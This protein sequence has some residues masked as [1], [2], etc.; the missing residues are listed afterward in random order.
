MMGDASGRSRAASADLHPSEPGAMKQSKSWYEGLKLSALG[1]SA[2]PARRAGRGAGRAPG[3]PPRATFA[4][5]GRRGGTRPLSRGYIDEGSEEAEEPEEEEEDDEE[6]DGR[7]ERFEG[8]SA[9]AGHV[10]SVRRGGDGR[11]ARSAS[12]ASGLSLA[13]PEAPGAAPEGGEAFA[14]VRVGGRA[15]AVTGGAAGSV[16]LWSGLASRGAERCAAAALADA[17]ALP[18][19]P[20]APARAPPRPAHAPRRR[21]TAAASVALEAGGAGWPRSVPGAAGSMTLLVILGLEDGP[22]L[23]VPQAPA[24]PASG[25]PGC[26]WRELR[27]H[28]ARVTCLLAVLSGSLICR[29]AR[30]CSPITLLLPPP[31]LP[32]SPPPRPRLGLQRRRRGRGGAHAGNPFLRAPR[33]SPPA[34][35]A[36]SA[37]AGAGSSLLGSRPEAIWGDCLAAADEGGTLLVVALRPTCVPRF[38][39]PRLLDPVEADVLGIEDPDGDFCAGG[40]DA[41]AARTAAA[42]SVAFAQMRMTSFRSDVSGEY[43][44]PGPLP[45]TPSASGGAVVPELFPMGHA[46]KQEAFDAGG[47]VRH[48]GGH[49]SPVV[50]LRWWLSNDRLLA[51]CRD[52]S[53][54][55]WQLATG[56]LERRLPPHLAALAGL[57]QVKDTSYGAEA[58]QGRSGPGFELTEA[59]VGQRGRDPLVPVLTLHL[60]RYL[61]ALRPAPAAAPEGA[62]GG[63]SERTLAGAALFGALHCWGVD[64]PL[65]AELRSLLAPTHA[66]LPRSASTSRTAASTTPPTPAPGPLPIALPPPSVGLRGAGGRLSLQSAAC[67]ALARAL[68]GAP[69]PAPGAPDAASVWSRLLTHYGNLR[70]HALAPKGAP[71]PSLP[72]LVAYWVDPCEELQMAARALFEGAVACLA[73]DARKLAV[74][75]WA[76]RLPFLPE[77]PMEVIN[78]PSLPPVAPVFILA[79]LA[80]LNQNPVPLPSDVTAQVVGSLLAL[81]ERAGP[82]VRVM[83]ADVMAKGYPQWRTYIREPAALL[84]L[85]FYH[86][87]RAPAGPAGATGRQALTLVGTFEP[88]L[89]LQTMG[90]EAARAHMQPEERAAALLSLAALV[91]KTPASIVPLLPSAVEA[92]LKCLDPSVPELRESCLKP[93]TQV[94]HLLTSTF[95]QVAFNMKTQQLAVGTME[96]PIVIYDLR[97][98]TRWRVLEGHGG[99]ITALALSPSGST[100]ASFSAHDHT[101]RAWHTSRSL[102]SM[103]RVDCIRTYSLP[104]SPEFQPAAGALASITVAWQASGKAVELRR[105]GALLGKFEMG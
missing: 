50:R 27:G 94:L 53:V 100:L 9:E 47:V 105:E 25:T 72:L 29:V 68:M 42:A 104:R 21:V 48:F 56:A 39:F 83:V 86:F 28:Q 59:A 43:E 91:R 57:V 78:D 33:A 8:R 23:V 14:A 18:A 32:P 62:P 66:R 41:D 24:P 13:P 58:A 51:A 15:L 102:F 96:G 81:L 73:P 10:K 93:A 49:S 99:P 90:Q 101:L 30:Q 63:P 98:A 71:L 46:R 77:L 85:L 11:P 87:S 16:L 17:W 45:P 95:A 34:Q 67:L 103:L 76:S 44:V 89:F 97:T 79:L 64:M 70:P 88:A 2:R 40:Y 12:P 4:P 3:R 35:A 19:A 54:Y 82:K 65:D 52:G 6:E 84:R 5:L 1:P 69:S 61:E 60:P 92:I 31:L 75:A 36:A 22:V 20:E 26:E 55:V 38:V 74:R 7:S 37:G 80:S